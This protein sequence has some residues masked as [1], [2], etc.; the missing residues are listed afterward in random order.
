[1]PTPLPVLPHVYYCSLWGAYLGRRTGI[2]LAFQAVDSATS[3]ALD[4]DRC[5]ILAE[6]LTVEWNSTM[7][8]LY[9]STVSGWDSRVY[10]LQY[11]VNP[12]AT[13]HTTGAGA[14][15]ATVAAFAAAA[16]I[17][18]SVTRRGRGSQSHSAISPLPL[19]ATNG[20]GVHMNDGPR[21][22]LTTTFED[23]IGAVQ[24]ATAASA[25]PFVISYVQ[26]SKKG[27]GAVYPITHS[28]CESLLGTERSRTFRP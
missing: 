16:V 25:E 3:A 5:Q 12:A 19:D 4:F 2:T 13:F 6:A 23:F 17:K 18:H 15:E 27:G 11:P 10:G 28:F 7:G 14:N 8:P 26:L 24:A 21:A 20:D 9:P 22:T 1:M